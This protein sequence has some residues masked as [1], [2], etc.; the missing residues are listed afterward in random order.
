MTGVDWRA[1]ALDQLDFH[2][3]QWRPG[4]DTLTDAEYFWE[5]VPGCWS[6]RP[7]ADGHAMDW[8]PR[9]PP[10]GP[11]LTTIAWRLA[12]IAGHLFELRAS[13]HF[14][15]GGYRLDNHDYP[16]GAAAAR[17]HLDAQHRRWRDG[18]GALDEAALAAP[19]GPAEGPFADRP[20]AE[21]LLHLNREAIHHGAEVALLRDLYRTSRAGA[22][23][24]R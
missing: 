4:L 8:A 10:S 13:A 12:H 17:A 15:D 19:V 16:G 9:H 1:Q 11:P 3:A 7:V 22:A 14:G 23:W 24:N 6:I 20:Y 21:L 2:W 5:P 18:I